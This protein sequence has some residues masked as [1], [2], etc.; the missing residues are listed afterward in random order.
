MMTVGPRDLEAMSVFD[1]AV[2]MDY[3]VTTDVDPGELNGLHIAP[4]RINPEDLADELDDSVGYESA[5]RDQSN[6]RR[7]TQEPAGA[8]REAREARLADA[9]GAACADKHA[10]QG[11][12]PFSG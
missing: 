8:G 5:R 12:S 1:W 7:R 9:R 4:E 11:V 2:L 10:H 6:H 3:A